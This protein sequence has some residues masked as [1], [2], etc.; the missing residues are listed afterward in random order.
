VTA[1]NQRGAKRKRVYDEHRPMS[2][3]QNG[4]KSANYHQVRY[5]TVAITDLF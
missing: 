4:I 5:V 1:G 2:D 3:I